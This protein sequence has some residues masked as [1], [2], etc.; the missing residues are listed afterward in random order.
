MDKAHSWRSQWN[1][2]KFPSGTGFTG[3]KFSAEQAKVLSGFHETANF[4]TDSDAWGDERMPRDYRSRVVLD[5]RSQCFQERS[6]IC[7]LMAIFSF[8]KS[9]WLLWFSMA[10]SEVSNNW[11]QSP[12]FCL[13]CSVREN[14]SFRAFTRKISVWKSKPND[15]N[16][17]ICEERANQMCR[18]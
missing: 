11:V 15:E 10:D 12:F 7:A 18:V 6:A 2:S 17:A 4:Q 8:W 3:T 5:D 9:K 1:N 13:W 14:L 16:D